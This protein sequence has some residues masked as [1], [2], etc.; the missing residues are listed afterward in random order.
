MLLVNLSAVR[1]EQGDRWGAA[2][3]LAELN[4]FDTLDRDEHAQVALV[5]HTIEV[6]L[7]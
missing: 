4:H 1:L 7:R 6:A 3:T 5:R 2:T